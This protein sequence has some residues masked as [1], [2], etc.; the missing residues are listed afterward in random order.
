[1]IT[2]RTQNAAQIR[3]KVISYV[4]QACQT[5]NFNEIHVTDICRAAN[6]SK[7]T[8]FKY[9]DHKEDVL[10]LYKSIINTGICIEISQREIT[11]M[12][13]LE[14]VIYRFANIIRETPS[15]A[16]ELVAAVLHSKPPFLPVI[17]TDADKAFFFPDTRFEEVNIFSFWNL[18]EGFMLEGVLN[19]EIT[20]VAD[21]TE[22]ATMFMATLYGGIV[23]SYI[24]DPDQQAIVFTNIC[25]SWVKCLS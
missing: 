13:G 11:S 4:T 6:I 12:A 9:F 3:Y 15:L 7:V 24:K 16:R 10:I 19:G 20:R 14:H 23:T 25:K 17:L 21:A 8:F 18:I 5:R 22:L 2:K 1:M